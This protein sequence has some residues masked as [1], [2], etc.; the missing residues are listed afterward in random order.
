M[1]GPSATQ[2]ITMIT[3][4]RAMIIPEMIRPL[5]FSSSGISF[6]PSAADPPTNERTE[7]DIYA[8]SLP[9]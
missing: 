1:V 7:S 4:N 9:P 2:I 8:T 5:C 3:T 6:F